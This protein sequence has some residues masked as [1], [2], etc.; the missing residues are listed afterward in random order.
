MYFIFTLPLA[1]GLVGYFGWLFGFIGY[2]HLVDIHIYF[3][4]PLLPTHGY[5]CYTP[6]HTFLRCL[7]HF[8]LHCL[9]IWLRLF[10][11]VYTLHT[12]LHTPRTASGLICYTHTHTHGLVG[13]CRGY[14]VGS[15]YFGCLHTRF[16][17]VGYVVKHTFTRLV[18]LGCARITLHALAF[19]RFTRLG[20]LR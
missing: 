10:I 13:C 7:L 11:Y 5:V 8:A 18:G 12:H 15:L 19:T 16:T 2:T 17:R 4:L 3:G 1:F 20:W 14:T 9:C 6:L